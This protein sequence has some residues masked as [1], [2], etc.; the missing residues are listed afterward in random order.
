MG[1]RTAIRKMTLLAL[2]LTGGLSVRAQQAVIPAGEG[3]PEEPYQISQLGHLVWMGETVSQS[4]NKH[5]R[6]MNDIDASETARWR[7]QGGEPVVYAGFPVI[8]EFSCCSMFQ[9]VFDGAGHVIRRLT[10]ALWWNGPEKGLFA[11]IGEGGVVHDLAVLDAHFEGSSVGGLVGV[12]SGGVISNCVVSA[13]LC[14]Y[15]VGGIA[16]ESWGGHFFRCAASGVFGQREGWGRYEGGI[17]GFN[18]EGGSIVECCSGATLLGEETGGVAITYGL[19]SVVDSYWDI[20]A[21]GG[22]DPYAG[23]EGR[24]SAEMRRQ[25][26]F[27]GWDFTNVWGIV[28]GASMPYL[29]Q[30]PPPFTLQVVKYLE[31]RIEIEPDKT[32]YQPGERVTLT[33][34]S[35]APG[36]VFSRWYGGES[37][38]MTTETV[39]TMDRHR[40]LEAVFVEA[41]DIE[42]IEEMQAIGN[43][44]SGHYR[45]VRD[46]DASATA[47]WNGGQGFAPIPGVFRGILDGNGH[48]IRGLTIN[49]PE[50]CG[51]GVFGGVGGGGIVRRLGLEDGSLSGSDGV[52]SVAASVSQGRV[53][54]CYSTC[55]VEGSAAVGGLVGYFDGTLAGCYATGR[56]KG[57]GYYVGGL[58]G[59]MITSGGL[60]DRCYAMGSV[61]GV[62]YVGGL[63]GAMWSFSGDIRRSF[64]TGPVNGQY[65]VGGV[66]GEGH[67]VL[68]RC[69]ASG[70]VIGSDHGAGCLFGRGFTGSLPN[71]ETAMGEC[72]AVGRL[73]VR[74]YRIG[75]LSGE[76]ASLKWQPSAYWDMEAS[77]RWEYS[78]W[79]PI[80][81]T[82]AQMKQ[83]ANYEDWDFDEVWAIEEGVSYPY[84]QGFGE[85]FRLHVVAAG[86]GHVEVSPQKA[87]YAP[88]EVVTL[89]AVPAS[90]SVML[91]RWVGLVQNE[92]TRVTTV[93]MDI[94][95]TVLAEFAQAIDVNDIETLQLIGSGPDYPEDGCYRLTRDID[96]TATG[97]WNDGAG[98]VPIMWYD[99]PGFIGVIDGMGHQVR[100]LTLR[101][102]EQDGI[103]LVRLL[104]ARG[105]VRNLGLTD[106]FVEGRLSAGALVGENVGGRVASCFAEADVSAQYAGGLVGIHWGFLENCYTLG[107]VTGSG[108]AGGLAGFVNWNGFIR[109]CY[110]AAAVTG[111]TVAGGLAGEHRFITEC[112]S[113]GSFWDVQSSGQAVSAGMEAGEPTEAMTRR[114]TFDGWDF[115]TVWGIDEGAG[116][117][118]LWQFRLK[119]PEGVGA[120]SGDG[121]ERPPYAAWAAAHTNAWGT[122]DFGDVPRRDFETAWLLD[123]CPVAGFAAETTFAVDVIEVEGDE[124]R[125]GLALTVS[126]AAKQGAVNGL[127]AVEGLTGLGDGVWETV[128]AQQSAGDRLRFEGGR[129]AVAFGRPLGHRFF[130][131]VLRASSGGCDEVPRPLGPTP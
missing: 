45:L 37:A 111:D 61:E 107:T 82:T 79:L 89:T 117:P 73:T 120:A 40:T 21:A 62:H 90:N 56:V 104:G 49:R 14:G 55:S 127:L 106:C 85:G 116:Y 81:R 31:G 69:F 54:A 12:N 92:D 130:R 35:D 110:S 108:A 36:H 80:G 48:V 113:T 33:A 100:G 96:A 105:V 44:V 126:G 8:G 68:K 59:M 72:Y 129:A 63:V 60:V 103:G 125:I 22:V 75:T 112:V 88:G 57:T 109:R 102:P 2:L 118:F 19:S 43:D 53:E 98:F 83:R 94:H 46:I 10:N 5:Y 50:R 47:S 13:R 131:P 77:G 16:G 32:E 1:I 87:F 66:I 128:A 24:H 26:T 17:A 23:G 34:Y 27:V 4:S 64:A 101:W 25:E 78:V 6:L 123:M 76:Y 99:W 15:R 58:V 71:G 51:V 7:P 74:D 18:T 86:A 42:T 84:L 95:K 52:G 114:A 91:A 30:F 93:R 70:T 121:S 122:A 28:E 9:G 38:L 119:L 29:R 39:V 67:Q 3:T 97:S 115:S 65:A 124:I 20:D 41:T 11:A